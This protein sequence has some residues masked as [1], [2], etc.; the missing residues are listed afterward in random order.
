M[1][2][3]LATGILFV[4]PGGSLRSA[5]APFFTGASVITFGG[6]DAALAYTAERAAGAPAWLAPHE[7]TD[8]LWLAES[9]PGPP[10]LVLRSSRSSLCTTTRASSPR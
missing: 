9:T 10:I 4:A 2:G 5:L 7:M 8:G 3:G 6:A 1:C